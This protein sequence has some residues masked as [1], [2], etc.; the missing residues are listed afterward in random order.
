MRTLLTLLFWM[1]QKLATFGNGIDAAEWI[2]SL[3]LCQAWGFNFFVWRS[4]Y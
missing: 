1:L 3:L 2:K 4:M